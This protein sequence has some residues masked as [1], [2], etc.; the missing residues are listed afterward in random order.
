MIN[1]IQVTTVFVSDQDTAK[2]FYTD[3][4]GLSE[5]MDTMMGE[6]FRWLEVAPEKGQASIALSTPFPGM[7]ASVVGQPTGIIFDVDDVKKLVA[8]LKAKGANITQEPTDQPWGGIEARV[9]DPDGNE[10]GLVER[11]N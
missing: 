1:H 11:T 3:V 4:L 2:A 10:Y 8:D 7:P 5:R 9:A 6:N